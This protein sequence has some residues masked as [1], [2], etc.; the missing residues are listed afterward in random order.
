MRT[1]RVRVRPDIE[2]DV[3][4][5]GSRGNPVVMLL[6]GFPESAH[7]WRHQIQPL[8]D[9]GYHVLAP[10]QRGYARSSAP[11]EI[12]AYAADQLS[13]DVIGLL[14]D[15]GAADAA[16]V[17]HDW[18]ALLA[19]HFGLVH[20]DRTRA[21]IAASVPYTNWPAP[22]IE[23]FRSQHGDRF[24]YILYFQEPGVAEAEFD[25]DP[26]GFLRGIIWLAAGESAGRTLASDLPLAGTTMRESMVAA[27]GRIPEG[28][29]PW[30][31]PADFDVYVDQFRAGG[32]FGPVSWYRN[33]DANY[34]ATKGIGP[35]GYTTSSGKPVPTFF[36][37]GALDPVIAGRPGLVTSMDRALPEHRGSVLIPD[38]GH[39]VQQEA[40]DRFNRAL[41]DALASVG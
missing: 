41:L 8:A 7:S 33:F 39:W 28:L 3:V 35:G 4:E 31:T 13:A 6:H 14:D 27:L 11:R 17:G 25:A 18:G 19:W 10:D 36:I 5:A 12:D 2:L 34:E 29:P 38:V 9:A 21:L 26:E 24:F 32:F 15:V 23:V 30:L 1:R 40:P 20:P 37:A 16:I 22:P